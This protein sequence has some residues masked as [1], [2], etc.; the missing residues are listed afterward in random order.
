MREEVRISP[1]FHVDYRKT[2]FYWAVMYKPSGL[3]K[4]HVVCIYP[5]QRDA[6]SEAI[7]SNRNWKKLSMSGEPYSIM[8]FRFQFKGV[9]IDAYEHTFVRHSS[10]L[11]GVQET[12]GE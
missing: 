9:D 2:D 4:P 11:S 3:G 10:P 1:P 7:Q 5:R 8:R 6:K 12:K